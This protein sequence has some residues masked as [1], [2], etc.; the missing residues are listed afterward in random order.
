MIITFIYY[1]PHQEIQHLTI[2]NIAVCAVAFVWNNVRDIL[3]N[4][5][6]WPDYCGLRTLPFAYLEKKIVFDEI[7]YNAPKWMLQCYLKQQ[8]DL[9]YF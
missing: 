4:C 9:V 7:H 5:T 8:Q 6:S 1:Y 2:E 3:P